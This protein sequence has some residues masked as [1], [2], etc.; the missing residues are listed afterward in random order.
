[1]KIK[2]LRVAQAPQ[3]ISDPPRIKAALAGT[4]HGGEGAQL[5]MLHT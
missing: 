3:K 4:T 1:M 2:Y 5:G